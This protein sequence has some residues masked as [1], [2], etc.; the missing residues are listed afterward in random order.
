VAGEVVVGHL[1]VG[2]QQVLMKIW[3]E[4]TG[5]MVAEYTD[6]FE[7]SEQA[8]SRLNQ[9]GGPVAKLK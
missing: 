4:L 7:L 2:Q 8:D 6:V 3:W 1:E 5:E 9:H